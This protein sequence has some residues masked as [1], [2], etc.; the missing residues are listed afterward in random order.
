MNRRRFLARILGGAAAALVLSR[1]PGLGTL[2]P[3]SGEADKLALVR[4][5][6]QDGVDAHDALINRAL[7]S[8][9][10]AQ[11]AFLSSPIPSFYGAPFDVP[12]SD[13]FGVWCPD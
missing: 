11:V 3:E 10:P 2:V 1:V 13:Y 8:P 5:L 7:F 6:L 9:T 4:Q 12:L